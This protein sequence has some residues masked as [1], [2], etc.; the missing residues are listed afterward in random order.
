MPVVLGPLHRT[1][2]QAVSAVYAQGV[3]QIPNGWIFSGTD[4]LTRTDNA[5]KEVRALNPA[6]P[7]AWTARA[8]ITSVTST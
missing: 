7:A 5:L 6:L 4:S 8:S 1:S 3:A 2:E